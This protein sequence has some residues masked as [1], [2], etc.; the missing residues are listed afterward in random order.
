MKTRRRHLTETR[1]RHL[2]EAPTNR[3]PSAVIFDAL[4]HQ[5]SH[6]LE[7]WNTPTHIIWNSQPPHE[8]VPRRPL[9]LKLII[10][11]P[12]CITGISLM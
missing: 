11:K 12:T 7:V 9:R 6:E 2:M 1:R 5:A 8:R 10:R 3:L 4:G